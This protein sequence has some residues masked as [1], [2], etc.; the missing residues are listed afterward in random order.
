MGEKNKAGFVRNIGFNYVYNSD[1][2]G[3]VDD[4][5]ILS[6]DYICKLKKEIKVNKFIDVCLFRMAH[7]NKLVLPNNYDKNI[8][9][10]R[11]GISFAI[12]S[13]IT[14]NVLFN[15]NQY[16]DYYY[17]K[18]LEYKKYKIVISQYVCYFVN[19]EY[20]KIDKKYD[21]VYI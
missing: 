4:D 16:E 12:K 14:K 3:F 10:C 6:N 7:N 20:Y 21:R 13:Y 1:W 18:E 2:I 15:N 9:K 5:D 11:V 19:T 17:L 8:A